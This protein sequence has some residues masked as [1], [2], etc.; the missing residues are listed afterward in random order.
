MFCNCSLKLG[1]KAQAL[2]VAYM[3]ITVFIIIFSG[4]LSKAITEKNLSLRNKLETEA[5]YMAEGGIEDA[6]SYF[7]SSIA[8]YQVLPDIADPPRHLISYGRIR[9]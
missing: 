9:Y 1:K 8:D 3:V 2:I 7:A 5:F 4:L 6:I